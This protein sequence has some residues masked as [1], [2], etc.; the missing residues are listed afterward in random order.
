MISN[1]EKDEFIREK[2]SK[3]VLISKK[4]DELFNSYID[5]GK[6]MGNNIVNISEAKE[7]D[8]KEFDKKGGKKKRIMASVAAITILFLGVNA[9]AYTKGYNNI[10][11]LIRKLVRPDSSVS[12]SKDEIL[13]DT[14]LTISYE[15]IDIADGVTI[16]INK[17]FVS[18]NKAILEMKVRFDKNSNGFDGIIVKD[19]TNDEGN[20]LVDREY[21]YEKEEGYDTVRLD[22]K[23]F[24]DNMKI[25]KM[26]L[27]RDAEAIA[28]LKIN[29]EERTIDVLSSEMTDGMEKL[30]E[31]E[32]KQTLS[33]LVR[34]NYWKDN[35]LVNSR[36]ENR[37]AVNEGILE[38][39]DG[40]ISRK[41]LAAG[42]ED[43]EDYHMNAQNVKTFYKEITGLEVNNVEE[44]ISEYSV[45]SYNKK[46]DSFDSMEGDWIIT[47]YVINIDRLN[48][49]KGIY[50]M[51]FTYCYIGYWD[52]AEDEI[53]SLPVYRT[54]M[55]LRLNK[56]YKYMKFQIDDI[57]D[58]GTEKI[59]EGKDNSSD[60]PYNPNNNTNTNST[61]N[62]GSSNNTTNTTNTANGNHEH[63][64]FIVK[65]SGN[66]EFHTTL[67]AT[68]TV[69]CSECGATKQ[70]PHNFG[71]WYTLYGGT[72]WTLWCNDCQRYIY[73]TDYDF[74]KKSG[75]EYE[76]KDMYVNA[77]DMQ[78][79]LKILYKVENF[80]HYD[81]NTSL[82]SVLG[83]SASQINVTNPKTEKD[84]LGNT[85]VETNIDYEEFRSKMLN[86]ISGRLFNER[87]GGITRN[88]N[89]KLYVMHSFG[90]SA[91]YT[92]GVGQTKKTSENN[93]TATVLT[94]DGL[95]SNC[96]GEYEVTFSTIKENGKEVI[97]VLED[98]VG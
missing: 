74:V 4:A 75:Y 42:N 76:D 33:E 58:I 84:H 51:T 35:E 57:Y 31:I 5:G 77:T 24:N 17:L 88:V 97:D 69:K 19:F 91:P 83:F 60:L 16:Q 67:D 53:D 52:G 41:R 38:T 40:I 32:L 22:L 90:Y 98:S 15:P 18:N 2:F 28:E 39:M 10:F 27:M 87:F 65:R 47:P 50:D 34:I 59:K 64:W 55:R 93:Y 36:I 23:G 71:T 45:Y 25:L 54:T 66:E 94:M 63:K 8:H 82:G 26:E 21:I 49:S 7:K 95:S 56:D 96:I 78:E 46:T 68:H 30:S 70:E 79:T 37:S 44:L 12:Y 13:T 89:G 61:T 11:F 29:L 80:I 73:T 9:Y 92:N 20:K 48:Y 1:E 81:L 14:D 62:N 3:D 43:V 85:F 6:K 72:A 86:Y